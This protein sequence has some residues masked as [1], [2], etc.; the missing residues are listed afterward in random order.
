MLCLVLS[1]MRHYHAVK[2][3]EHR[4]D[5]TAMAEAQRNDK[6]MTAYRTAISGLVL[7]DIQFGSSDTMLLCNVST[8]QP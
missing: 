6:E 7:Q 3:L 2:K 5:F 8:G 4:V 1:S